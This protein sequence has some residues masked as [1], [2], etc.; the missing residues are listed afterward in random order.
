[1]TTKKKTNYSAEDV[2]FMLA[3]YNPDASQDERDAQVAEI[4]ERLGR[5]KQAIIAKLVN[6]KV[7]RK[8]EY[9]TKNGERSVTKEKRVQEIAEKSGMVPEVLE[10]LTKANVSVIK[11]VQGLVEENAMLARNLESVMAVAREAGIDVPAETGVSSE[12][13]E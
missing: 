10:S 13:A 6:L 7:Y 8:K 11:F 12:S 4:A 2:D 5:K 9:Q 3:T 1:M